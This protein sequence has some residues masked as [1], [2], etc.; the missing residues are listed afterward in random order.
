MVSLNRV[1]FENLIENVNR[2]ERKKDLWTHKAICS[3]VGPNTFCWQNFE[4]NRASGAEYMIGAWSEQNRPFLTILHILGPGNESERDLGTSI[5]VTIPCPSTLNKKS[6]NNSVCKTAPNVIRG[7]YYLLFTLHT[8]ALG[9]KDN[10]WWI[11][12]HIAQLQQGE[13]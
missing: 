10:P 3:L 13:R 9:I 11:N 6:Y 12:Y 1:W 8:L 4:H 2:L 5:R 7:N